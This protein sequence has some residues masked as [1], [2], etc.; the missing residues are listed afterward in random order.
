MAEPAFPE[1]G[2]RH[3]VA[4][5]V[6]VGG[7]HLPP[8]EDDDGAVVFEG[9][10]AAPGIAEIDQGLED[11]RRRPAAVV[12]DAPPHRRVAQELAARVGA[13][14]QAVGDQHQHVAGTE[15]EDP[16]RIIGDLETP[17]GSPEIRISSTSPPSAR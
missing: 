12:G 14:G 16:Q 5:G 11:L 10:A 15:G 17:S 9:L 2:G 6:R 8:F 1:P 13:L 7:W 4:R 3:T